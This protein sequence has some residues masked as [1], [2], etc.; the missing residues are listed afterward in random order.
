MKASTCC[1]VPCKAT[2][3]PLLLSQTLTHAV[4]GLRSPWWTVDNTC[5][6][7]L[8]SLLRG[9]SPLPP[10]PLMH[11]ASPSPETQAPPTCVAVAKEPRVHLQVEARVCWLVSPRLF[12]AAHGDE[13]RRCWHQGAEG[14]KRLGTRSQHTEGRR[15]GE[16]LPTPPHPPANFHEREITP[17]TW[18]P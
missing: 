3:L 8:R 17:A 16:L 12:P 2:E 15:L 1:S 13:R 11:H 6:R 18:S 14:C 7:Q 10:G 4:L 5:R 9:G